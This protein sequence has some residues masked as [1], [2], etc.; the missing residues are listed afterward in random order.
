M[1]TEKKKK[2]AALPTEEQDRKDLKNLLDL[3]KKL[4]FYERILGEASAGLV[5]FDMIKLKAVWT[6]D[7][8]RRILGLKRSTHLNSDEILS[9]Y[10]PEDQNLLLE[11][12]SFF[13]SNKKDP[14]T[15]FY[16]FRNINGEFIWFYTVARIFRYDPTQD[17]FEVLGVSLNFSEELIYGK[18]LKLFAQEKLQKTNHK[19]INRI[20]P[21]EKEIIKYIANGFKMREIAELLG[22]SVHTVNNHRK[23]ILIKLEM[24]NLAALVNFAVENG[25]D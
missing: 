15:A 12:R 6:N 3:K 24:K 14:Y 21:R 17:V 22:L 18:N 20:T 8:L 19:N 4:L 9:M 2:L 7:S 25:L 11:M 13:R 16:K 23:N 5:I 1:S 10:H